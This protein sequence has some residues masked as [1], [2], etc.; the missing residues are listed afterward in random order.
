MD[1]REERPRVLAV[2][3]ADDDDLSRRLR[4]AVHG[5]K[6]Q[7]HRLRGAHGFCAAPKSRDCRF[8][9]L[10]VFVPAGQRRQAGEVEGGNTAGGGFRTVVFFLEPQEHAGVAS[11]VAK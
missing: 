3:R 5:G 9:A 4:E 10:A 2:A 1:R 6:H 7:G 11:L 8:G